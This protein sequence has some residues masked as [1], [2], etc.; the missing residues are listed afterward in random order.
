MKVSLRIGGMTCAAC[1]RR[2]EKKLAGLPGVRA[3]SVNLATERAT[4][5]YD[6]R[7]VTLKAIR[8]AVVEAGYDVLEAAEAGPGPE[9]IRRAERRRLGGLFALA[10]AFSLPLLWYM[11]AMLAGRPAW[12]PA[13]LL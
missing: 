9:E 7:A 6:P 13:P 1:V 3:A 5:E 4:V 10:L 2:I 8:A 11:L 12:L